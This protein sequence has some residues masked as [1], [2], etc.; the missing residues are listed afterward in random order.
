[1]QPMGQRTKRALDFIRA[2]Q[3]Q[4]RPF[5]RFADI[6]RAINAASPTDAA[7]DCVSALVRRGFVSKT[8]ISDPNDPRLYAYDYKEPTP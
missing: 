3:A 6:G 2:E 5:P 7:K 8:R 4:G 1:M